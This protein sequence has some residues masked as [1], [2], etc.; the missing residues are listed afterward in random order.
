MF[1]RRPADPLRRPHRVVLLRAYISLR[2]KAM[3]QVKALF[4]RLQNASSNCI[5]HRKRNPADIENL[6][7]SF[8]PPRLA[9]APAQNG[10][11]A[12]CAFFGLMGGKDQP[13]LQ[14]LNTH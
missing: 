13:Q 2:R 5:K 4:P 1:C 12:P 14:S 6:S 9:C 8:Y 3:R 11:A 7:Q 10:D